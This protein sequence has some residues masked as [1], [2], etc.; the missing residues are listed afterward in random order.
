[1]LAFKTANTA[2]V[3]KPAPA[4]QAAFVAAPVRRNKPTTREQVAVRAAVVA[5]P[6]DAS[7]AAFYTKE[8]L[9]TKDGQANLNAR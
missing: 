4:P 2:A 1:M 9:L 6:Q 5:A 8:G 7:L 3:A